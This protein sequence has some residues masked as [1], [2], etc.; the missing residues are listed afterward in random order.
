MRARMRK[1]RWNTTVVFSVVLVLGLA[2][3]TERAS[4]FSTPPVRGVIVRFDDNATSAERS[5]VRAEAGVRIRRKLSIPDT[6]VVAVPRGTTASELARELARAPGV[7]SAEPDRWMRA[8]ALPDDPGFPEQWSL[9]NTGQMV[10]GLPGTPGADISAPAA[11]DVTTGSSNVVVAVVDTGVS[12]QHEDLRANIDPRGIDWVD[13]DREPRDENGHG[14]HVAGIIA[15]RGDNGTGIAGV[16]WGARILPLRV[17]DEDGWGE[18]SDI[19]EAVKYAVEQG[20]TRWRIR[21]G[22]ARRLV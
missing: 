11:W 19:A 18:E 7:R 15:A 2:G 14:T 17:L 10:G 21:Q 22:L 1:A 3:S 5:R 4:A 16:S 13:W 20:A 12:D 6:Q 9:H 8:Q